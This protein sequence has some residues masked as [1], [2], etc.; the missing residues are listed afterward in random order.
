M[1]P[2]MKC[3]VLDPNEL[4]VKSRWCIFDIVS[5]ILLQK[6]NSVQFYILGT[7]HDTYYI[8]H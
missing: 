2:G 3:I 5:N 8:L 4:I 6:L 7:L 1:L